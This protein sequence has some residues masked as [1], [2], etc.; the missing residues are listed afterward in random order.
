MDDEFEQAHPVRLVRSMMFR[1]AFLARS[2]RLQM[3]V[4]TDP[5]PFDILQSGPGWWDRMPF[6]QLH[7][8]EFITLLGGHGSRVA[9][10]SHQGASLRHKLR[11]WCLSTRRTLRSAT[12]PIV[13]IAISAM[14]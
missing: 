2:R 11:C 1:A 6:D 14:L 12:N 13:K 4:M 9:R 7:R 3:C 5:R 8:R 10:L